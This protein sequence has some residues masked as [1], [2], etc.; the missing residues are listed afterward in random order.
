MADGA[1]VD[2]ENQVY[3]HEFYYRPSDLPDA[4]DESPA[5]AQDGEAVAAEGT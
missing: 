2:T 5:D 3:K 4:P 1:L